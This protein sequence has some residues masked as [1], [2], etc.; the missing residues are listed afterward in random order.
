MAA[1]VRVEW[2]VMAASLTERGTAEATEK[3]FGQQTLDVPATGTIETTAVPQFSAKAGSRGF[4]R[5]TVLSGG[6]VYVDWGNAPA[7]DS[8]DLVVQ[9]GRPALV[10]VVAG[11]KVSLA[12]ASEIGS[13]SAAHGVVFAGAGGSPFVLTAA[14]VKVCTTTPHTR[15]VRISPIVNPGAY[16][17]EWVSV[18]AGAA[19]PG[20]AYGLPV[21]GGEDF[22]GGFPVGDIYLKSAS[23][24]TAIVKLGS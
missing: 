14:W 16:D 10:A 24:Q 15:G 6:S 12:D 13:P 20:D 17:I 1:K 5:I 3:P 21:L 9:A 22:A 18:P 11:Q 8:S 23:G 7:A 2:L 4:A 19:A